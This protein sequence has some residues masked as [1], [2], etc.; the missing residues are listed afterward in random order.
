M[1]RYAEHAVLG[2]G[3][4][5]LFSLVVQDARQAAVPVAMDPVHTGVC[6]VAGFLGSCVPDRLE[7]ASRLVGPNHRGAFHSL[8]VLALSVKGAHYFAT[9]K[10]DSEVERW[11]ADIAGAFCAGVSS[12]LIADL[13]TSQ[14]L[15]FADKGF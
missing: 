5:V 9:L 7:P 6:A 13:F 8:W 3:A 10:T 1:P 4:G 15:N 12:H 14:G 2:S 11:I